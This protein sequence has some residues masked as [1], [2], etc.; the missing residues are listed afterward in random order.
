[1]IR[2]KNLRALTNTSKIVIEEEIKNEF[3]LEKFNN[4]I[5]R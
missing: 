3:T 4:D 1:M 5:F 2:M